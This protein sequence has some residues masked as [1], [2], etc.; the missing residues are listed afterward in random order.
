MHPDDF[1]QLTLMEKKDGVFRPSLSVQVNE[2]K[3]LLHFV[4]KAFYEKIILH[5]MA[6]Q[7]KES[8]FQ[9]DEQNSRP[10]SLDATFAGPISAPFEVFSPKVTAS[11]TDGGSVEIEF[12]SKKPISFD[13]LITRG[14]SLKYLQGRGSV[15]M[16]INQDATKLN[17]D[18]HT[19]HSHIW[20]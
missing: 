20:N 2:Q 12:S 7:L 1:P 5:A 18:K 9:V 11:V 15:H 17:P 10:D 6:L 14:V 8:R 19:D 3:T 13:E 16:K 4:S